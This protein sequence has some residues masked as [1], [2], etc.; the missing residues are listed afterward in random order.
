MLGEDVRRR[1]GAG[2]MGT[3]LLVSNRVMHY[4]VQV[5]NDFHKRFRQCGW[6]FKV[7]SDE[8]EKSNVHPIDFDFEELP[9]SFRAYKAEIERL[10]PQ[11][12]IVFLHLRETIFWPLV[13][14]LKA[15]GTP[16]IFWSKAKN[17]DKPNGLVSSL[18]YPYVHWL[19]D[20]LILYAPDELTHI[21]TPARH[22]AFAA[23]NTINFD[24]YPEIHESKDEIKRDLGIPFERVVLSVGR[25]GVSG[26]RKKVDRLI[27]IFRQIDS[28]RLGLV[29]VG[30]GMTSDLLARVNPANTRYL[31]E[32]HDADNVQISR[33]FK[34]AD[35]FAIPGHVGLGLNQAF[36]W[37]LPV[38]TEDGPQPPEIHYLINGRNGFIVPEGDLDQLRSKILYLLNDDETRQEFSRNA[39]SDILAN[40][41]IGKMFEGFRACVNLVA[42]LP[43]VKPAPALDALSK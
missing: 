21:R 39:R 37:G 4:R 25:M 35:V 24:S 40:A 12:V 11:V 15:R 2:P 16:V 20:G 10:N 42:G 27:E 31:G 28:K 32:V 36:Y 8:L 38:I 18:L 19:C 5:Y 26:G 41:S 14:W 17:Y 1:N 13:H 22:K 43:P 6:E 3:I 29:I 23:N 30:S 34:M 33:I 9:F 7:R